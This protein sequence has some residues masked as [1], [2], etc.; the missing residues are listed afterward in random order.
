M[1]DSL[2]A[3]SGNPIGKGIDKGWQEAEFFKLTLDTHCQ[4]RAR[5]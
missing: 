2:A 1:K 5:P 4:N 3:A